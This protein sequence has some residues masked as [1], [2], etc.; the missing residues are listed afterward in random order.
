MS[1]SV[2]MSGVVHNVVD[3]NFKENGGKIGIKEV[4]INTGRHPSNPYQYG[5]INYRN[6][7]GSVVEGYLFD[8]YA[9]IN[10]DFLWSST[11][12][13]LDFAE[14]ANRT[15]GIWNVRRSTNVYGP[16]GVTVH[17][18]IQAGGLV[19]APTNIQTGTS[20]PDWLLIKYFKQPNG[21]WTSMKAQI[22][23]TDVGFAPIGMNYG[24]SKS[25]LS[26]YGEW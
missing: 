19:A 4:Y 24:S 13:F 12:T 11:G 9:G 18:V 26:V 23:T 21:N 3:V 1:I 17:A 14:N 15:F 2:N 16:D 7:S 20:H 10:G 25:T 8:D 5:K 6:S 22:G